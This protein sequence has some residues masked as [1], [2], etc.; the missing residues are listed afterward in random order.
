MAS[1]INNV[2]HRDYK[3]LAD[4][5][6]GAFIWNRLSF[7]THS[8]DVQFEDG[9]TAQDKVGSIHGITTSTA[10]TTPGFAADATVINALNK[11]VSQYMTGSLAAGA[12]SITFTNSNFNG[13]TLF[14]VY[15]SV[16]GLD[17]TGM[18]LS[19]TTLTIT[20]KAIAQAATIKLH[21]FEI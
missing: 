13:N 18:S 3:V 7:W 1:I 8:S 21:Y 17:P 14:D 12:T 5:T 6:I 20:F 11:K 9:E 19:G 16:F 15:S 4:N 2:L 10:I